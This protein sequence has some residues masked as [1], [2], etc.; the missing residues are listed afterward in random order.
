[1]PKLDPRLQHAI[2]LVEARLAEDISLEDLAG[3]AAM[4]PFHF[5]RSFKHVTGT[6][7]GEFR[8]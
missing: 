1:V 2:D 3:A 8:K 5:S 4:S 7:P 6:T